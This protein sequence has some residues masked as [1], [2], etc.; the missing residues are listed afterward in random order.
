MFLLFND[1]KLFMQ[2]SSFCWLEL[3]EYEEFHP[4]P[5][6]DRS[7]LILPL[8]P[9]QGFPFKSILA[10]SNFFIAIDGV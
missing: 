2:A 6:G 3:F 4:F 9:K 8:M 5:K 7:S 1:Q 10:A